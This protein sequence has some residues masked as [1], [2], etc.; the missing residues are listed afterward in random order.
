MA[1]WVPIL[2][3]IAG[4]AVSG[5]I[6]KDEARKLRNQAVADEATRFQRLRKSA[7]AAGFNPLTALRAGGTSTINQVA[8]SRANAFGDVAES[9]VKG[10]GQAY[11]DKYQVK[12]EEAVKPQLTKLPI[13][14]SKAVDTKRLEVNVSPKNWA[15]LNKDVQ[16]QIVNAENITAQS[17]IEGLKDT[18]P[19]FKAFGIDFRG[20]GAFSSAAA[21]EE[22]LG[23]GLLAGELAS[24]AIAGDALL[25]TAKTNIN[26][27]LKSHSITTRT[28]RADRTQNY[29]IHREDILLGVLPPLSRKYFTT[30]GVTTEGYAR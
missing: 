23:D 20:S 24:I 22:S 16:K 17:K 5:K 8:L 9:I 28:G 3:S 10:L 14:T 19:V 30:S 2:S 1:W 18:T 15:G 7:E 13:V 29:K 21:I 4:A 26:K 11:V 6:A 27:N 12:A 25:N